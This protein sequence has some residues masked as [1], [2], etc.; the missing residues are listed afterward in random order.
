MTQNTVIQDSQ[1]HFSSTWKKEIHMFVPFETAV[2]IAREKIA[3]HRAAM[4]ELDVS[5]RA[6]QVTPAPRLPVIIK[7]TDSSIHTSCKGRLATMKKIDASTFYK[8]DY[9]GEK[10]RARQPYFKGVERRPSRATIRGM[11]IN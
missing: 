11:F 7:T 4:A 5:V 8:E 3:R 1:K 10:R 6:A 2:Q 9:S